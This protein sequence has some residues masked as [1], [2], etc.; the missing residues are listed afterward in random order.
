M[1]ITKILE[2]E[3]SSSKGACGSFTLDGSTGPGILLTLDT[4]G[5]AC[6]L[7]TSPTVYYSGAEATNKKEAWGGIL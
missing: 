6:L 4:Q 1:K 3:L 2:R 5:G 7:R